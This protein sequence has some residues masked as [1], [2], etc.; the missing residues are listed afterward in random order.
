MQVHRELE[1]RPILVRSSS[2]LRDPFVVTKTT[3][4]S[5]RTTV[6]KKKGRQP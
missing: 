5:K 6:V 3:L 4:N 1:K 2:G